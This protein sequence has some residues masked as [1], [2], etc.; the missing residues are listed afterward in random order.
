VKET[1]ERRLWRNALTSLRD[2]LGL[3]AFLLAL[4]AGGWAAR[5]A[6]W[7]AA[8]WAGV[9]LLAALLCLLGLALGV[10]PPGGGDDD[11]DEDGGGE[12]VVAWE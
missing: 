6:L 11:S 2:G 7:L 12:G 3:V 5:L 4:R 8:G 1:P 9:L 10:P